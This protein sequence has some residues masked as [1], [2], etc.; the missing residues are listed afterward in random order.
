MKSK[1][2]NQL[3]VFER[4]RIQ[5]LL[6]SGHKQK[7]IAAIL[8]RNKSTISREINRNSK[9]IAEKKENV[10]NKYI[11]SVAQHKAY[12]KRKYAKYQGKKIN[13]NGGLQEYIVD[14]LKR[15][16]SPDSISGRMKE[17]GEPFYASKTAIYD[18]LRSNRGQRYCFYLPSKRY[19]TKKRKGV[20][21]KKS[22]IPNRKGIELRPLEITNRTRFG[23]FEADTIVSG[24][25]HRSKFALAVS[26]E[27]KA[28]YTS[29]RKIRSLK[30]ERFNRA[31]MKINERF[32]KVKSLTLD[33]GIEN[34]R[35]EKLE[36][37]TF[38]CDPYSSWQKGGVENANKMIRRYIPKGCDIS[39]YSDK[40]VKMVEDKL[41][42]RPRKSLGYKTPREIMLRN[43][44]LRKETKKVLN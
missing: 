31:I 6:E 23:H 7:E 38:F 30:P 5:A 44:M 36:I 11:S 18:W 32:N 26:Y 35:Y 21:T 14:G 8:K 37:P 24:K 28:K 34:V 40:Y 22:L 39:N 16:W 1:R 41:N 33:N 3:D 4:D 9:K 10:K 19:Y 17:G 13:E 29:I 42:N 2:Y 25:R 20:K 43:H 12:V 27:R 15:D